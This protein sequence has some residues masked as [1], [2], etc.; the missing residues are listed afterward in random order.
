MFFRERPF[1]V[2]VVLGKFYIESKEKEVVFLAECREEYT[3]R[4][5]PK[6]SSNWSASIAKEE[7]VLVECEHFC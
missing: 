4:F 2:D 1:C 7:F 3:Q 6:Q 5:R